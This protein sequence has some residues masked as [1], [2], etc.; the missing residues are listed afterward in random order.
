[1]P[2][3]GHFI[4]VEPPERLSFGED[5]IESPMIESGESMIEFIDLGESRTKVVVTSRLVA[6]EELLEMA[7]LGWNSQLD[8]LVVLLAERSG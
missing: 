6:T 8:K 3:P 5:E 1:M 7:R 4:V 2:Q